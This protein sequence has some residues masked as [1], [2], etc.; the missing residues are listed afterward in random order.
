MC[1]G[2]DSNRHSFQQRLG[3]FDSDALKE[4][5]SRCLLL[6]EQSEIT[7]SLDGLVRVDIFD[8]HGRLV[9]NEFEGIEAVFFSSNFVEEGTVAGRLEKYWDDK[10]YESVSQLFA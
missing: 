6:L 2:A 5:A 1:A 9:V 4:F 8:D 7:V 3:T 10:I